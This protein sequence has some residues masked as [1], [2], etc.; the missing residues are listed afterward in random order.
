MKAETDVSKGPVPAGT[1]LKRQGCCRCRMQGAARLEIEGY[2]ASCVQARRQQSMPN[3]AARASA[4][5]WDDGVGITT[6]DATQRL[7]LHPFPGPRAGL[8]AQL[9]Q[10]PRRDDATS[11]DQAGEG[12]GHPRSTHPLR[13]APDYSE[14]R[15]DSKTGEGGRGGRG[16]ELR[17]EPAEVDRFAVGRGGRGKTRGGVGSKQACH[18]PKRT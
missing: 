11:G 9:Q 18:R 8:D 1:L 17:P 14:I 4:E 10:P 5:C 13:K 12:K 3:A 7:L 15:A 6:K 2:Y 16:C